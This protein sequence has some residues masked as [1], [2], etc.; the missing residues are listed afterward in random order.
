MASATEQTDKSRSGGRGSE[1]IKQTIYMLI[2]I[3]RGCRQY[4]EGLEAQGLSKGAKGR[5]RNG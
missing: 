1:E 2:C 3:V 5:G 4:G